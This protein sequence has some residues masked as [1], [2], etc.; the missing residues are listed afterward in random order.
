MLKL[1]SFIVLYTYIHVCVFIS[2]LNSI[3][4]LIKMQYDF[5]LKKDLDTQFCGE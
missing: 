5:F 2:Y 1:L 4:V 3:T